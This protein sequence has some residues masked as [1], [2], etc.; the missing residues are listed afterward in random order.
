VIIILAFTYPLS[1]VH[2]TKKIMLGMVIMVL[3]SRAVEEVE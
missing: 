2:R 3:Q 1:N